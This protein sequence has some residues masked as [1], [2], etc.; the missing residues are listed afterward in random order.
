MSFSSTVKNEVCRQPIEKNCCLLAEL[1]A[2][3]RSTGVVTIKG[4]D[5]VQLV[6]STEN[7]AVAR[8]IYSLLKKKYGVSASVSV[9]RGKKLKRANSYRVQLQETVKVI[10]SDVMMVAE[11]GFNPYQLNHAIPIDLLESDCCKRAYIKGVF[12]GCGSLS[13]PEKGYH[14]EFVNHNDSHAKTFSKLLTHYHLT[15]KIIVRKGYHVVYLKESEQIVDVLNIIGAYNSL[16]QVENI[17]IVKEMRNNINRVIN[18]ETANLSKTVDA[19]MRQIEHIN[20]LQQFSDLNRLPKPL[21][22]VA[23]LRLDHPDASLKEIGEMLSPPIGKS[24]V[25]HRFKKIEQI[26][27]NLSVKGD[28][29]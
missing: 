26:A 2:L 14:L 3:V 16:L 9:S 10:L 25:N 13:D 7:A 19:S 17:R 5:H 20:R 29:L 23:L 8:R 1:A 18:C 22:D 4:H 27:Q 15:A 6:F 24:G 28:I 11:A 21:L 12:L